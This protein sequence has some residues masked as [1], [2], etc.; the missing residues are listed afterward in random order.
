MSYLGAFSD[1]YIGDRAKYA[2]SGGTG[3]FGVLEHDATVTV[4]Y[5]LGENK[6]VAQNAIAADL[7]IADGVTVTVP[8]GSVLE[9][10]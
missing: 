3:S 7:T 8:S 9:I 2:A 4:D 5:T 6:A 1:S 10:V